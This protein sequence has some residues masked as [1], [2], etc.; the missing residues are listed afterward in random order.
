LAPAIYAVLLG[1]NELFHDDQAI[2]ASNYLLHSGWRGLV[3]LFAN[4]YW[5]AVQGELTPVHYYRPFLMATFWLQAS[6][7]GDWVP[8]LRFVNVS[9]HAGVGILLFYRLRAWFSREAAFAAAAFFVAAP[10]HAEA[11][12]AVTGRSEILAALLMLSAWQLLEDKRQRRQAAGLGLFVL[13]LLTKETAFLFPFLLALADWIFEAKPFWRSDRRNIYAA[14]AAAGALVWVVRSEILAQSV[15]GGVP[16]FSSRLTAALTYGR[17]AAVHY[18]GP[19][20][21]GLGHCSDYSRPLIPDAGFKEASAWLTLFGWS[22]LSA[23][24]C[25]LAWKRRP[26]G[27]AITAAIILML[28]TSHLI[29]PLDSIGAERFL[30]LPMASVA[31]GAGWIYE[32]A[33]R[34]ARRA[35][36]IIGF[37][38]LLWFAG[39]AFRQALIYRSRTAFYTAAVACNPVSSRAWSSLGAA[40]LFA[41]RIAEGL[42]LTAKAMRLDPRLATPHY[43]LARAAYERADWA[44][45]ETYIKTAMELSAI[46]INAYVLG[47]LIAEKRG[48]FELMR[49]RLDRSLALAPGNALGLYNMGRYWL[50]VGKP[51]RARDLFKLYLQSMPADEETAAFAK[52]IKK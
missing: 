4:G 24:G 38:V 52:T 23:Y 16:Y 1:F 50:L 21:T 5:E 45:A 42:D 43:N 2:I 14:L 48:D 26:A 28:P 31:A 22:L 41:G 3:G 46:N 12:A 36:R 25:W 7:S 20:V 44:Q 6:M 40:H 8:A 37:A 39:C 17:F 19:I 47:A 9:L 33:G 15:A 18:V 10:V 11:V 29:W 35:V 51:E 49:Q 34:R 32:W 30:Y 27:F 13:A